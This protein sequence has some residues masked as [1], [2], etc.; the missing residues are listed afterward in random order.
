MTDVRPFRALRYDP[1]RVDLARVIVPPYDVIAAADARAPSSIAIPT[2]RSASSSTR[3]VADEATTDYAEIRDT[4]AA[5]RRGGAARD[6]EPGLLRVAAALHG[7]RR[8]SRTNGS[9]SSAC[10]GSRT[11]RAASCGPTSARSQGRRPTA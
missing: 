10:S 11:T 5:W 9:A 8:A 4:L 1:T 7:A 6:P 3:D 2:T